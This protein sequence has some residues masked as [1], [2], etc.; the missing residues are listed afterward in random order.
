MSGGLIARWVPSPNCKRGRGAARVRFVVI[1]GTWMADDRAALDRLTDEASEVSA[2]YLITRAGELIQM[3]SEDDTAWHAG[4]SSWQGVEGLNAHS[5]GIEL[6]NRG[7]GGGEGASPVS[8]VE[9]YT[10]AQYATLIT[11]LRNIMARHPAVTPANVLGHSEIS[12]GRKTDPG[13][14]FDWARL[15]KAGVAAQK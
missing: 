10:E 12:P 5:I 3:V 8:E 11:L 1:H 2:H 4:K 14:H 13:A 15:V 6:G 7:D 9:P